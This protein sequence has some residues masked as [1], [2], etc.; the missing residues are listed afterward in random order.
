MFKKGIAELKRNLSRVAQTHLILESSREAEAERPVLGAGCRTARW[1]G[2]ET[3]S[4]LL[5]LHL[6]RELLPRTTSRWELVAPMCCCASPGLL[7]RCPARYWPSH[8]IASQRGIACCSCGL[9]AGCMSG[10]CGVLAGCLHT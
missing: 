4:H 9:C 6:A 7:H 3:L 1:R 2:K 10:R 5:P 8:L